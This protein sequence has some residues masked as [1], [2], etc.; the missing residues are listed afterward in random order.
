M[1]VDT[2]NSN[3]GHRSS[4]PNAQ[5]HCIVRAGA[6]QTLPTLLKCTR[7]W[8]THW[9]FASGYALLPH[10]LSTLPFS[11]GLQGGPFCALL[12]LQCYQDSHFLGSTHWPSLSALT[13]P[14]GRYHLD[15][16]S[17]LQLRHFLNSLLPLDSWLPLNKFVRRQVP[18][19]TYYCKCLRCWLLH[20][21]T[22]LPPSYRSG[23]SPQ[24]NKLFL[25]TT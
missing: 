7:P 9:V 23:N 10:Y 11:P 1:D 17:S 14:N 21:M 2:L 24:V 6:L 19:L 16:W 25:S 4:S 3:Y 8:D 18:S 20:L 13:S 5:S 12:D 22:M 15:F